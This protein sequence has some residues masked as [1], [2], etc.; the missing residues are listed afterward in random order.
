MLCVSHEIVTSYVDKLMSARTPPTAVVR[1]ADVWAHRQSAR[2]AYAWRCSAR[3][4]VS[5]KKIE[6]SANPSGASSREGFFIFWSTRQDR[7]S[8]STRRQRLTSAS[9]AA[10][11]NF[12]IYG[13]V[14]QREDRC[15]ASKPMSVRFRPSPP[16]C[17][18]SSVGERLL[19]KQEV[20]GSFPVPRSTSVVG[21]GE[22][23]RLISARDRAD[24]L[25]RV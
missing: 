17:G 20:A 7:G 12:E 21:S 14:V 2:S 15:F 4:I 25:E 10:T 1:R 5:G 8:P 6:R 22:R 16:M 18:G 23:V 11:I 19:A 13:D 9:G 24:C 3:R